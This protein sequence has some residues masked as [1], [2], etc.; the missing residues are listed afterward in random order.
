MA[1]SIILLLCVGFQLEVVLH[2]IDR[3]FQSRYSEGS[4]LKIELSP[5]SEPQAIT[6]CD[7]L[8]SAVMMG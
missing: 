6:V 7:V 3:R 2:E 4:R 1:I 5:A 8:R